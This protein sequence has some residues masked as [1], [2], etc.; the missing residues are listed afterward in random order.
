MQA[1][2]EFLRYLEYERRCSPHTITAYR[3]DLH[4]FMAWLDRTM[5]EE[6]AVGQR[7]KVVRPDQLGF[8][9]TER[10][11]GWQASLAMERRNDVVTIRRKLH[12]MQSFVKF[13]LKTGAITENPLG[14][15][16]PPRR[17]RRVR[18][19]LTE[20]EYLAL[21]HLDLEKT[22]EEA[23][24]RDVLALA[25]IRREELATLTVECCLLSDPVEPRLFIRGKGNAERYVPVPPR[26]RARLMDWLLRTGKTGPRELVFPR[27]ASWLWRRV[28]A[29][30]AKV[31]VPGLHPH[32]FRHAYITHMALAGVPLETVQRWVGHEDLSTTALYLHTVESRNSQDGFRAWHESLGGG[33]VTSP[34]ALPPP[35]ATDEIYDENPW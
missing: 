5:G 23:A 34:V 1:F 28:R 21:I 6:S 29:W 20:R 25:G 16:T 4:Q 11:R 30:G 9:T 8:L 17:P 24:V 22:P 3:S 13:L 26:L 2:E 27:A 10:V 31:G 18:R 32:L 33:Y 19:G 15:V 14:G 12:T 35:S 7:K